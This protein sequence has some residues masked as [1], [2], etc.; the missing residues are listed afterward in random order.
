MYPV[1]LSKKTAGQSGGPGV[2]CCS[3]RLC[4]REARPTNSAI[5]GASARLLSMNRFGFVRLTCASIRTAVANPLANAAEIVRVLKQVA[6]S[7]VVLFPEL[8]VTGYTCA[9]LFGQSALLDAGFQ[10]LRL[11]TRETLG[12]P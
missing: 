3:C 1:L 12:R 10:A 4:G 11:I 9:D 6:D 7:D 5:S 8:S 2:S